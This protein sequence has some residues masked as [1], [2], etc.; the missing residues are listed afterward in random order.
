MPNSSAKQTFIEDFPDYPKNYIQTLNLDK[1]EHL[2]GDDFVET[3]DLRFDSD[4]VG[5]CSSRK[6]MTYP[7]RGMTPNGNWLTIVNNDDDHYR[8]GILI[9]ECS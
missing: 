8:Q 5:L 2:F 1:F 6:R 9:E 7:K 4:E 3:L